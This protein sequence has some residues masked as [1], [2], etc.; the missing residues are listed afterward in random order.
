MIMENGG[1]CCGAAQASP[2]RR[3]GL[4][5]ALPSA[6]RL[7]P[8][9]RCLLPA[10]CCLLLSG[11]AGY[12]IGN[13]TLF[14]PDI[15]TVY[16]P[17]VESHSFRPDLGE[18]LTE[19]ICKQIEKETPYKV[20]GSPNADSILT[21]KIVG[22]TKRV[23]DRNKFDEPRDNEVNY[24]VQVTWINRKGDQIY[25]GAVPLPPEFTTI[26][27]STAYIPEYGQ[28]YTT[29]EYYVVQ[30]MAQQIVGL[31]ERPW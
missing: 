29:S 31:M 3:P 6:F 14:P 19:A 5:E 11:C 9:A 24:Q 7:P 23:I 12:Q 30:K 8:S 22:E 18:A 4:G 2:T 28:S 25:N 1:I 13:A 27:Q 17:M 15:S 20:V 10:A 26:G 21:A 16:V